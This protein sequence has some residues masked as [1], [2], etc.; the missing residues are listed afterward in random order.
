MIRHKY[1][2]EQDEFLINNVKGITLKELVTR[3]NREF[4]LNLSMSAI[5]NRKVK[6]KISSG[7][8]GGQFQKGHNTWNKGK[9]WNEYMSKEGQLNSRKTTFKKGNV[10]H[11]HRLVGSERITVDGYI[12]VKV[13]EPNKWKLK[14]RFIYE[15]ATGEK[16]TKNDIVIFLDGDR[17]NFDINNLVRMT[18]AELV[19]Y[20]Q[21]H[22]Y[23]KEVEINETAVLVAKLKA[24]TGEA[25]D[26]TDR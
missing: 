16:L 15:E 6:L 24:K 5:S 25:R 2:K 18:R 9:T 12:E 21:D 10:P 17:Q 22:L 4:N 20:N 7:I 3:F 11:N 14:Q 26:G 23:G 19:R 1:T 13:A 8:V